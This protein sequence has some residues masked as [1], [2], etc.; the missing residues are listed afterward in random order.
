MKRTILATAVTAA[1]I[2]CLAIPI[3][4]KKGAVYK[5]PPEL[6]GFRYYYGDV[7]Y[8]RMVYIGDL[9]VSGFET[10]LQ[11]NLTSSGKIT[12][13]TL[14]LGP[15]GIDG[16]NCMRRYKEVL[17]MLNGKYGA[18]KQVKVVK[19]PII[20]DLV[21][22]TVCDP[23]RIGAYEVQHFWKLKEMG[24]ASKLLGDSEGFYIEIDY[25]FESKRT[26]KELFKLL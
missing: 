7:K 11:L 26:P 24:I 25:T 3:N 17:K 6:H 15:A 18:Y 4:I 23:I 16:Q 12:S 9:D 21:T 14:I 1:L 19:D 20:D 5:L 2:A 13:Y 10:E 22:D 8:G